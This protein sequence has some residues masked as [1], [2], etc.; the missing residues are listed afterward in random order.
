[1][2]DNTFNKTEKTTTREQLKEKQKL[3]SEILKKFS[4]ESIKK[5]LEIIEERRKKAIH[6]IKDQEND[7]EGV[8]EE[9]KQI[10]ELMEKYKKDIKQIFISNGETIAHITENSPDKMIGGKVIRS[11]NRLNNYETQR[12]NWVFA[13]SSPLDGKNLYMA[14]NKSG[15]VLIFPDLCI[16]GDDNMQIQQDDKG[17]NRVLLR[18][19]NYIY[20]IN[21][22]DFTP[23]VN[24]TIDENNN[25]FFEFSEE[26]TCDHD[27][28][29]SDKK[30]VLNIQKIIDITE[31][32][33]NFQILCDVN[34]TSK[35]I[36]IKKCSTKR[37]AIQMLIS[38]VKDGSLRYI[39]KEAGINISQ[40]I[41]SPELE[42]LIGK[43]SLDVSIQ[44]KDNA[45][46]RV[47][48]DEQELKEK[49]ELSRNVNNLE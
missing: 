34:G 1:M 29:I 25:P 11:V 47:K 10:F 32:I 46:E 28:D 4:I 20:Q 8:D 31:L 39:N 27:I 45:R 18:R 49:D 36:E 26:W 37:K 5:A 33:R 16:Y 2:S 22:E 3:Y 43:I 14:R 40:Y 13:S 44:K 15:M 9:V 21:P 12:G 23:V 41:N 19:P 7:L 6:D 30:T 35:A 17:D 42:N 24:L 38:A 48:R